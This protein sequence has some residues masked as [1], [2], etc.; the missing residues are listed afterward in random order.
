MDD[1]V[2]HVFG[3]FCYLCPRFIPTP[4]PPGREGQNKKGRRYPGRRLEDSPLPWAIISSS[5]QDFSLRWRVDL[6][7]Y[8]HAAFADFGGVGRGDD[9]RNGILV[10]VQTNIVDCAHGCLFS[11]LVYRRRRFVRGL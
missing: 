8:D 10:N 1:C 3:P 2:T 5:L 9:D 7:C 6:G 11:L 4:T